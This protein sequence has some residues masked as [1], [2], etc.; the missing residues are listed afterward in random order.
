MKKYLII[1]CVLFPLGAQCQNWIP[2][3]KG[4]GYGWADVRRILPDSNC[5]YISGAFTED[6]NN[7]PMMG[8]AKWDGVKWDSVGDANKFSGIKL[9][10]IKYHD[11]LITSGIFYDMWN[12]NLVKL[13]GEIWDTIPNSKGLNVVCYTEKNGILYFGGGFNKCGNDSTFSLGKYDGTNLSGLTPCYKTNSAM[14]GCM[15]FFQDT[16]YVG[17]VLYLYPPFFTQPR[18]AGF[19]KWDGTNLKQV[20][21]EFSINGCMLETMVVY[22]NEL[23]IGGDFYKSDGFTGNCI[24]KW[25]GHNF[26]E[27]GGGT[28]QRVTCMK[29]YNDELYVGGWFTEAGGV[30]SK[31][32][33]K[34]NGSQWTVLNTDDFDNFY[35]VRDI[36]IYKDE[37]YVAGFFR[38][39][40][41]DS[42]ASI[43][44]YNHPLMSIKENNYDGNSLSFYPNPSN[45]NNISVSFPFV[46][47][48]DYEVLDVLGALVA[49][50]KI[51]NT[52]IIEINLNTLANGCYFVKIK[53]N[54]TF[55]AGKFI[56]N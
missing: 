4:I 43:A 16:L 47:S 44:K 12:E 31:N 13:N 38:K 28:N 53:Q 17:G 14:I 40:G 24:M 33:A 29:V 56:K 7:V 36:C 10:I 8:I 26:S 35:C 2:L 23:Y 18:I 52:D 27:V 20:S 51:T 19:A 5:I 48:G 21:P 22:K 41:N 6:G 50:G 9:G 15:T 1:F 3:D 34:W 46:K 45:G 49:K 25:D 55:F 39:I 42:I 11:T 37:L 32:I 54:D 30:V